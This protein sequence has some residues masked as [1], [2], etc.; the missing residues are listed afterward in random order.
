MEKN[1]L[2]KKEI[3]KEL[4]VKSIS[5]KQVVPAICKFNIAYEKYKRKFVYPWSLKIEI[6]LEK[7]RCLDNGLPSADYRT[8]VSMVKHII[9]K[10]LLQKFPSSIHYVGFIYRN[11][12]LELFLYVKVPVPVN[13]FL[14]QKKNNSV[15]LISYELKRDVKWNLV[16]EYFKRAIQN[17]NNLNEKID[18]RW[19]DRF[20][21]R[22]L[23]F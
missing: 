1:I 9:L 3:N 19:Y 13:H 16:N 15:E 17:M 12:R 21:S 10:D 23:I 2:N 11:Y 7:E 5:L 14:E 4:Q 6:N 18:V 20:L 8:E 22:K